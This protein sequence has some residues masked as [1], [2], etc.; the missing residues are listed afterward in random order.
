MKIGGHRI[1]EHIRLLAPLFILIAAVWLIRLVLGA[2]GFS[3]G[4]V[5]A[6]SVTGVSAFAI[7]LATLL[8]HARR[9]GSYSS[10]VVSSLL[11][12]IWSQLLV[13][14]AIVFSVMTGTENI[15]TAPEFSIPG[16]DTYHIRH[17]IG[18]LTFGVGLGTLSG[19]A[20]GCLLLWMLRTL[21]PTTQQR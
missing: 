20:T 15:F 1:R 4:F 12:M 8:I 5:R 16:D 21:V 2:A 6:I 10:V 17:I 9:F 7:L 18:H 11:L 14:L 13:V 3:H 19:A